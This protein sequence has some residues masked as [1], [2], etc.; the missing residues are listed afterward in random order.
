V[1]RLDRAD[2][3]GL[4]KALESPS[5]IVRDLAQQQLA[6]RKDLA[7]TPALER[8]AASGAR[9]QTRAQALWSLHSIGAITP[10]AVHRALQDD[11]AGVRRQAV[12]LSELFPGSNP[13][14][15]ERV[16]R[17]VGDADAGVRLQ[18][19]CSL[20]EWKQPA[21]GVA[22]ARLLRAD[23]DRFIRAAAMSSA[24]PHADTLIAELRAS[25]RGDDPLLIEIATV[26]ENA[27]ALAS[28]LTGIAGPAGAGGAG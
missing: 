14:M 11:H 25:G 10:A 7:A 16:A 18:V 27:K 21:A 15:L 24:L 6:W 12:R 22:L 9:P 4:V 5:G 13:E 19:A 8:L 23:D 26:T 3:Q 17:L 1:P 28:L 2:T 20:G